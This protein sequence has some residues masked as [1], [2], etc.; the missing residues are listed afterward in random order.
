MKIML[1]T[2][3]VSALL[4]EGC[5]NVQKK[6]TAIPQTDAEAVTAAKRAIKERNYP[7]WPLFTTVSDKVYWVV[8]FSRD[9]AT[10]YIVR[11]HKQTGEIEM[12]SGD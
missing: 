6:Q 1:Y 10:H 2:F 8:I 4:L 3:C 5:H 7:D 9:M 12:V 11:I